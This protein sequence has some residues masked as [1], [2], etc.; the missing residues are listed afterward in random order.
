MSFTRRYAPAERFLTMAEVAAR[1][2]YRTS[3]GALYFLR[4]NH[5]EMAWRG[6]ALVVAESVL[7]DIMATR[8]TG[9]TLER[10]TALRRVS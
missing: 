7:V 4:A 8:A 6:K 9:N 2:G 10:A 5:A 3:R 1:L